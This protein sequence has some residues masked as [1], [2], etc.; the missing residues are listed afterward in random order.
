MWYVVGLKG[1]D[2]GIFPTP[3]ERGAFR[4]VVSK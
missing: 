2:Y 1:G 4:S 3:I